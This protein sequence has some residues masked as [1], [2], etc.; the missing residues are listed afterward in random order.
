MPGLVP[1]IHAL[2]HY[3]RLENVDGRDMGAR[4]HA[5]LW[6]AMPGHD[7]FYL[8]IPFWH[9]SHTFAGVAGISM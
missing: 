2:S 8:A 4:K 3:Y 9:A 6:T 5:V 7:A 1:G